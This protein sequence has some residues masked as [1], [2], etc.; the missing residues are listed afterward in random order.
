[1]EYMNRAK[2]IGL[3]GD[4]SLQTRIVIHDSKRDAYTFSGIAKIIGEDKLNAFIDQFEGLVSM[5]LAR[6]KE[7][8]EKELSRF[9]VIHE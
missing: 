3:S 2:T 8:A 5:E 7:E 6:A 1:M 9:K 4:Y